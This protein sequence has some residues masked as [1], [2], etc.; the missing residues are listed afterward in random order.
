MSEEVG[1]TAGRSRRR[2]QHLSCDHVT[3]EDEGKGAMTNVLELAPFY[4][5]GSQGQAW[6]LALKGLD[7]GQLVT[8]HCALSLLLAF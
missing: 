2:R 3:A 8:T 1:F 4:L 6:M 7:A 5:A